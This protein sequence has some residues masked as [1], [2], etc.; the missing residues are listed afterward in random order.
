[1]SKQP[2]SKLR[3]VSVQ[4]DNY[5]AVAGEYSRSDEMVRE[6][7]IWVTERASDNR[8]MFYTGSTWAVTSIQYKQD[9]MQGSTGRFYATNSKVDVQAYEADWSPNYKISDVYLSDKE[10]WVPVEDVFR[11]AAVHIWWSSPKSPQEGISWFYNEITVTESAGNTYYMTNGFT[12]GYMGIQDRSPKW[13]IFSIWDKAD[14]PDD[15]VGVIAQGQG[16]TVERF[17]GEGTGGKSY[18][19]YDWSV[20]QTYQLIVNVKPDTQSSDKVIFTGWFRI[21]EQ[22]IWRM[23]ASF[24]VRPKAASK[25][26]EDTYSFLENWIRDGKRRQGLWGTAWFKSDNSSWVQAT[27]GNGS[28]TEQDAINRAVFLSGDKKHLGMITGGPALNDLSLGP[29]D[30]SE[31]P[32]PSVLKLNPLPNGDGCPARV[33]D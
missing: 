25:K 13:V 2:V 7:N 17:G 30:V 1:M 18:L 16:V 15:Q 20:G 4:G 6:K 14:S 24:R 32:L 27:H 29:Y 31:S 22:N 28:T 8:I 26:F 11:S 5:A 12:G 19:K 9:I 23:L 10:Q 3:L 21:P 33:Q